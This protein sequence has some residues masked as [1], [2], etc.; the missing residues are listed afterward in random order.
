[1]KLTDRYLVETGKVYLTG[2]QALVR[3]PMEQVRRDRRA[4]LKTGV[5]ISGYE[6]SPLGGYDLAL[7]RVKDLLGELDIH[8]RPAV[9]EDL[10]ATAIFGSQIY[11]VMGA[12]KFDGVVGIWYGKGPGVDRSGD[13]FRHANLAGSPGQCAALVLAGDDH[14][15]KSSS[16]PHQSDF[17]LLSA[18]IP[19]LF[20]GNTQEA[21]DYGLLGIALSRYTGAWTAL[22]LLTAVCD[23][24]GSV[25][26]D[27][28][29][30]S[31]VFPEGYQKRTDARLYIPYTN[32]MEPEVN[33]R[34]LE[35]AKAFARANQLNRWFGAT[36]NAWLGVATAG[37]SYYDFMQALADLGLAE[38]DL[39]A[40]GVRVAKFGMTFPIEPRFARDFACGLRK[41]LVLEEKRSFLEM[42]LRDSL[43]NLSD[44]PV[45]VGKEDESGGPLLP[46]AY[47]LDP[48]LI[49]RVFVQCL[50]ASELSE[51]VRRR[52]ERI[53]VALECSSEP[54]ALRPPNFCSGCPHNRSTLLLDHQVAGGGIGCHG[55]SAMLH[56]AN[57]GYL[58][59]THMGGEGAPW[60]GM[61]PF[62]ERKHIF[63]NQG[64]GTFFHS[65]SL[66]VEAC[67]A[68]GVNITFKI[69]YNGHVAMTGG[70]KAVG[71]L[72]VPELTRKLEAE[73]V[74][75]IVVLAEDPSQ[76]TDGAVLA[77][78]AEVRDRSRLE[79]TLAELEKIP[80]VTAIIYDQQCAAEKRRLRSRGKLAEPVRRLVIHEEVCEGCGDCV[81]QSNCMSLHPVSTPRGQKIQIH[82]SSCNKDYS[83]ALG[84]CPSFLTVR[85][86]EGSG[87]KKR[88]LPKL[89]EAEVPAPRQVAAVGDGYRIVMPGIGGTGVV[90]INAL[91]AHAAVMDGLSVISLDQTGLAQK[92]GAVVSHLLIS[93]R[94]VERAART[95][96]GNAD[97]LLGFDLLGAAATENLKTA[98]PERT[99]AVLN[100]THTPTGEEIRKRTMLVGPERL[101]ERIRSRTRH[102]RNLYVDAARLAET[103]FG[104][105]LAVNLFLTGVAFQAGLLPVSESSLQAAIRLNGVDV[106]RNLQVFLWGRKYYEDPGFV[107]SFAKPASSA[108]SQPLDRAAELRRYQNAA[109]ARQFESFV[110][111]VPPPLRETVSYNLFKLMAYKDEYEVARLLT[112]PQRERQILDLWEKPESLSYHLH[113]PLLRALGL[114]RKLTLG[115]WFKPVLKMLAAL[116]FLRGT[117]FDVFG[118]SRH[119]RQERELID[120][121]RNLV[122]EILRHFTPENEALAVEIASLPDQIRGYE[123]I[124]EANIRRVKQLAEEKLSALRAPV[125]FSLV[126]RSE[127]PQ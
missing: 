37:K 44:R 88:P 84:D 115:P 10:A 121:Y 50:P 32:A 31:I 9:N 19:I 52:L 86:A 45:I 114:K 123:A 28:G 55:M 49:A 1:M 58:F 118:Y 94:P 48:D 91:L 33:Y 108:S 68:A 24:G 100:T 4:G 2:I 117:V 73:G 57:R 8:V 60:I 126:S 122:D 27:P 119:R 85:I 124:K 98:D 6:G 22:K 25:E 103:L 113:P 102:G 54:T 56:D 78:N 93:E 72:P 79:E 29:R 120:W 14:A 104:T 13:V 96:A 5:L 106:E 87:L 7:E 51:S 111:K 59:C 23:G 70:Q 75:K 69:L 34:R 38:R 116:R 16:I 21:L 92:G 74:K 15:C 41:I 127:V 65:G 110:A 66:A 99:V 77:P 67:V 97:L 95:N 42:Q 11:Q 109:Y 81:K 12:S 40:L 62:V 82:Q 26:V 18:A 80:G 3:L 101:V 107:E 35:A 43:F 47:E 46:A 53:E 17:S 30:L 63:Q 71:A 76:Y 36:Q 105:H 83:C 89:P 39:E 64:D 61:S 20:P 125:G 112:D 90:T